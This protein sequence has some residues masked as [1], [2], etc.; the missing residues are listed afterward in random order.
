[1]NWIDQLPAELQ[2]HQDRFLATTRPS[3]QLQIEKEAPSK[4]WHSALGRIL[5]WPVDQAWPTD[6]NGRPLFG[7]LQLNLAELPALAGFPTHGLL[8]FFLCDDAFWGANPL[9]PQQQANFRV[10]YHDHPEPEKT[11]LLDDFSFLPLYE[12]LPLQRDICLGVSG[13][14]VDMPMPPQDYR[15]E[16]TLQDIFTDFGDQQWEMLAA[17]KKA[18]GTVGHR[19]GGYASFIQDDP[20]QAED[21][22]QWELL[23]QLDTDPKVSLM[24]GDY[25][26]AHWFYTPA[27][28]ERS[29]DAEPQGIDFGEIWYG[30]ESS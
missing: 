25:G 16:A 19:L 22:T 27:P 15:F 9:I 28:A 20:R 29:L 21:A 13:T 24:W 18:I 6:E 8:Q 11:A 5:Y 14:L 4:R 10:V 30:W 26:V 3:V 12:D 17:Y 7:L 23:L 1:M 2:V